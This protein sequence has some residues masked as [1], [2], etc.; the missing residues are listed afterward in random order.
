MNLKLKIYTFA[1]IV[2]P[3]LVLAVYSY[4]QIRQQTIERVYEERRAL[5]S[6]SAGILKEK[7]DRINDLGL[8]FSTRVLLCPLVEEQKW[9]AAIELVK[10][11]PEDFDYIDRVFITDTTGTLMADAPS[12]PELKGKNY[13]QFDWYK[14]FIKSRQPYLSPV[15]KRTV[16]PYS[17]VSAFA[18]PIKNK[19]GKVRGILVLQVDIDKLLHWCKSVKAGSNGFLYVADQKGHIATHPIYTKTDSIVDYSTVSVV[20]KALKGKK[21]VETLYNTIEKENR[22]TAYE[23]IPGYGWAVFV[24]QEANAALAVGSSLNFI[25][26]IYVFII[27]LACGLAYFIIREMNLRKKSEESLKESEEKFRNLTNLSPIGFT[28]TTLQGKIIEANPAILDMMGCNTKEELI[29]TPADEYYVD[30]KDREELLNLLKSDGQVKN[31]EYRIKKK[32]GEQI[33]I[34]NSMVP[35]KLS[36]KEPLMLSAVLN[37]TQIKKAEEQLR[38]SEEKF[39]NLMNLAPVGITLSAVDGKILEANQTILDMMGFATKEELMKTP[40]SEFFDDVNDR[41]KRI[42]LFKKDGYVK[43]YQSRL[44]RKDGSHIWVSGHVYP[45][46]LNDGEIAMLSAQLDITEIKKTEEKLKESEEKFRNLMNFSPVGITLSTTQGK[47]LESNQAI[48][49]MFGIASKEE[50]INTPA[51][52]VYV[53]KNDRLQMI[54][55]FKKD[56]IIKNFEVRLKRKNGEH[57]WVSSHIHPL[58][59]ADGEIA[60][61]SA[62]LDIT[63]RKKVEEQLKEYQHFFNNSNDLCL[64]ANMEGYFETVN[65]NLEKVLG[66]SE[67]EWMEKPFIEF[68]H[69]EDMAAVLNEYGKQKTE[70]ASVMNFSCRFRK[71]DGSYVWLEWNSIPDPVTEKIYAIGRDITERKKAEEQLLAANKEL[72]A[73]S[74]SVSHD[75]RAPLR[76]VNGYAQM[77][78]ED[79]GTKMDEEGKRIT[80][81]IRYNA[82]KMGI[83]IDELLKFSR[84]GPKELEMREINM[85]EVVKIILAELNNSIT[86]TAN[87]KIGKLHNVKADYSLLYQVMFNLISNAIKYSSKKGHPLVEIFSEEKNGEIIFSVKDNGA[88]FDMKYYDKLF[89]VFQRLHRQNEFDGVGVGLALVQ[90]II[91]KHGGKVWAEGKVNEG[92]QFNFSLT[93][94]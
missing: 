67:K 25:I 37:I 22:L 87:I 62:S 44:R 40:V 16:P 20:P 56:G 41:E 23:P 68:I 91:A 52:D 50:F 73:F 1:G 3:V 90:R 83:L 74:Y 72:E 26:I 13:A 45:F 32:N 70:A 86:H 34:S 14:G 46:K 7:M 5:A 11:I 88:G 29:N 61:L 28:L 35:F 8:S 57:I 51:S 77:L 82:L 66:Y 48:L 53:D 18:V 80:E 81:S 75:L 55:M 65:P 49:D 60:M 33:W 76:A 59:L 31:L 24:T 47:I 71:I 38:E 4:V 17:I 15:Y 85:N 64:I 58:K 69:P 36:G 10:K 63:Y 54:E 78:I 6:L 93:I 42:Q 30:K 39:R 2:L 21:N 9:E 79:Y 12:A 27:L 19:E 84:L 92:A 94:T 43:N 89:G